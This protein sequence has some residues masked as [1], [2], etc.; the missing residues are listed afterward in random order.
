[1]RE[2]PKRYNRNILY[3]QV[4]AEPVYKLARS[5]GIT[6]TGLAKICRKLMVPLPPR[7]YWEKLQAG[8]TVDKPPLP[9]LPEGAPE[10]LATGHRTAPRIQLGQDALKAIEEARGIVAMVVGA[11]LVSPHHLVTA[12]EKSLRSGKTDEKGMIRPRSV[13]RLDIRVS[14]A[15]LDRAL[16]I[17]D[18]LIKGLEKRAFNVRVKDEPGHP[19]VVTALKETVHVWIEEKVNQKVKV[20]TKAQAQEQKE[21]PWRYG[22]WDYLPSGRLA[23]R[24]KVSAYQAIRS[25]WGDGEKGTQK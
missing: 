1:M 9:P 13:D 2:Q 21:H 10:E 24:I 11:E 8:H 4:W 16:R 3:Q 22:N 25:Q 23:L 17:M 5:Y 20:L 19:T 6:G 14:P 12:A 7:G 18:A 15:C